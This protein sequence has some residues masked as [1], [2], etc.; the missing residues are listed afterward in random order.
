MIHG[1]A[2]GAVLLGASVPFTL[3]VAFP[4]NKQLLDIHGDVI[5]CD[6]DLVTACCCERSRGDACRLT[7][8]IYYWRVRPHCDSRS[9]ARGSFC[10]VFSVS[11]DATVALLVRTDRRRYC[12]AVKHQ[13]AVSLSLAT[14]P[15]RSIPSP[16]LADCG[17]ILDSEEKGHALLI[18]FLHFD[19][20]LFDF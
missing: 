20:G 1:C 11:I 17:G 14:P 6:L 8:S 10:A 12:R 4:T 15:P 16:R 19:I 9:A 13:H 5:S 3:I 7:P 18:R 2:V